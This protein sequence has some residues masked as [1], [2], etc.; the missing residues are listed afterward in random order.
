MSIETTKTAKTIKQI[1]INKFQLYNFIKLCHCKKAFKI[2]TNTHRHLHV[3]WKCAA[4]K[5]YFEMKF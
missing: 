2:N 5:K 4:D 3:Y 1:S